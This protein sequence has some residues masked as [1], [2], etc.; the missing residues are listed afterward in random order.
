MIKLGD[1]VEE[2]VTGFTGIVIAIVMYLN[3][4][5]R[6]EVQPKDLDNGKMIPADW[7]YADQLR[8]TK[9]ENKAGI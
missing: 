8:T 6:Y 2:R 3:G 5:N 1:L 9:A 4:P 7:F